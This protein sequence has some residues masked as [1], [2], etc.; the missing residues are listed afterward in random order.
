[1]LGD[2][3]QGVVRVSACRT[4][5][6]D[7]RGVGKVNPLMLQCK[8]MRHVSRCH[9]RGGRHNRVSQQ[10]GPWERGLWQARMTHS[11]AL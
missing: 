5:P 4:C 9:G 7:G 11:H 2:T 8:R 1:M 6:C 10:R 3:A